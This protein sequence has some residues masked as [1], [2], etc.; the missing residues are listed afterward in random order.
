MNLPTHHVEAAPDLAH[1]HGAT[2]VLSH[3][4]ADEG[5]LD[6]PL[7]IRSHTPPHTWRLRI[8]ILCLQP[9]CFVPL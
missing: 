2:A 7:E 1:A 9:I 3:V 4:P 5:G 8:T 6:V